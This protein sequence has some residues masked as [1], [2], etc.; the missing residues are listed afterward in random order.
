[1]RR[2]TQRSTLE[3]PPIHLDAKESVMMAAGEIAVPGNVHH[4]IVVR[5]Y[6]AGMVPKSTDQG[7]DVDMT[8]RHCHPASPL[9][10]VLTHSDL[11]RVDVS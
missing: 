5:V 10:T 11:R 4:E 7:R 6:V 1:M 9:C 2:P 8:P 3:L